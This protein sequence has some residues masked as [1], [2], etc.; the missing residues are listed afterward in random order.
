MKTILAR[1]MGQ[2]LPSVKR[3]NFKRLF[4]PRQPIIDTRQRLARFG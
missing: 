2:A 4:T 3:W 1:K